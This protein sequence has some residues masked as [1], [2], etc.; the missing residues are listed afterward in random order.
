MSFEI[1]ATDVGPIIVH[2]EKLITMA[3]DDD[4]IEFCYEDG[5]RLDALYD[6]IRG[7]FQEAANLYLEGFAMGINPPAGR[8]Y[9]YIAA[10]QQFWM[11]K[12]IKFAQYVDAVLEVD[13]Q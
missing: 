12:H 13:E 1:R 5:K 9:A 11:F 7:E 6:H 3:S 8:L 4:L 2:G 10:L